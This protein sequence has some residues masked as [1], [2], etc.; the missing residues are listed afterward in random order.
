MP[1]FDSDADFI[2]S[3]FA[4]V[5][6]NESARILKQGGYLLVACPGE[7]HLLGLK[8]KIYDCARTNQEKIPEYSDFDLVDT[9][10]ICF[11]INVSKEFIAPLFGMTPYYWK[12]SKQ[13]QDAVLALDELTTCCDFLLKIY[14]KK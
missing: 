1:F 2:I 11:D 6:D 4:P 14:K 5:C 7:N 12:S 3:V 8:E 9:K 10:H 13:T